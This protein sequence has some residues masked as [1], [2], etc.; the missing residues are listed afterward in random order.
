VPSPFLLGSAY[1]IASIEGPVVLYSGFSL[2]IGAMVPHIF[3][4]F[5]GFMVGRIAIAV[6]NPAEVA[7]LLDF[8]PPEL[9]TEGDGEIYPIE[10]E[11]DEEAA[12][13]EKPEKDTDR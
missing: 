3:T 8:R 2:L 13:G 9:G 7:S 5:A 11:E 6:L 1:H 10:E 12:F 4:M